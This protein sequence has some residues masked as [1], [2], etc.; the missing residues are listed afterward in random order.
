MTVDAG[1]GCDVEM[2]SLVSERRLEKVEEHVAD[3]R[4]NGATVVTGG[5]SLPEIGPYYYAPTVLT[6]VPEEATFHREETF[7]AVVSVYEVSDAAEAVER[8]NDSDY[9]LNASVWTGNERRGVDLATEI[10]CG[11]VNEAYAA[12]FAAEDAPMGGMKD[13]GIG[14]R[15]GEEGMYKC[16][17]SQTVAVR[18]HLRMTTPPGV[19]YGTYAR[20]MN[21]GTHI[22]S[23]LPGFR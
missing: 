16:T 9:G 14:R 20:L 1:Y 6:G 23:R 19:P 7:G 4:G 17:E 18:R 5:E 3:A 8:V 10:E 11:T 2:G 12:A 13:S 21:V 22:M 15:H